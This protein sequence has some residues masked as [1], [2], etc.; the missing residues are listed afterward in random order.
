MLLHALHVEI[1][2]KNLNLQITLPVQ[3]S[4]G[5][6]SQA[7]PPH[8]THGV[9]RICKPIKC[10]LEALFRWCKHTQ[11]SVQRK[12]LILQLPTVHSTTRLWLSIQFIYRIWRWLLAVHITSHPP[13]N[14]K[15]RRNQYV[16]VSLSCR[17]ILPTSVSVSLNKT[18]CLAWL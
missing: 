6:R 11:L 9:P 18:D 15:E 8:Y 14:T 17:G 3:K 13:Q 16:G 5:T 7:F 12:R 4:V 1:E 10:N 2:M